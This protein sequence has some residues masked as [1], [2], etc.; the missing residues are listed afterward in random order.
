VQ[1][2]QLVGA[3]ASRPGLALAMSDCLPTLAEPLIEVTQDSH[4]K[5]HKRRGA[6]TLEGAAPPEMRCC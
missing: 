3:L 2:I 6:G 5:V 4:P 1:A